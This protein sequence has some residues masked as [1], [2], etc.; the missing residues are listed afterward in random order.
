MERS[1]FN[2]EHLSHGIFEKQPIGALVLYLRLEQ[3]NQLVI[4][5]L[6]G[7]IGSLW[8]ESKY[9]DEAGH[10]KY[11]KINPPVVMP[12]DTND[13]FPYYPI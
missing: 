11:Y 2:G 3:K 8:R 10:G 12:V 1:E 9:H 7:C 5:R 6:E 4:A 13:R